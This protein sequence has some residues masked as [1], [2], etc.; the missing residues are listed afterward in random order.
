MTSNSTHND[1]AATLF[2]VVGAQGS[3]K[4]QM[5]PHLVR[6]LAGR[7]VVFD[8]NVLADTLNTRTA[9]NAVSSDTVRDVWLHIAHAVG[10][11]NLPT[12]LLSAFHPS[13]IERLRG[14]KLVGDVHY[15]VLDVSDERR[16]ERL[17][18][19]PPSRPRE[20]DDELALAHKLRRDHPDS[21]IDTDDLDAS[22]TATAVAD[23]IRGKLG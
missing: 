10:Q 2:V 12:V 16:K 13:D 5:F 9:F 17:A 7:A 4:T 3:G 1:V 21:L 18:Q 14:R 15:V 11:N 8:T 20:L 22:Q 23:V 19:D 6:E